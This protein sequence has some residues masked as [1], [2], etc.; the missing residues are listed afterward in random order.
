MNM[1]L[2]ILLIYYS[3]DIYEVYI[4]WDPFSAQDPKITVGLA[5]MSE[6][7]TFERCGKREGKN[8]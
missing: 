2:K 7:C 8:S 3:G 5:P 4:I 6:V 1:F